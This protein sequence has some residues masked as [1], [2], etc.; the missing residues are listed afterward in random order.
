GE[1]LL[2]DLQSTNGTFV[3]AQRAQRCELT[4]GD[5]IQLG[6]N[7][8]LRFAIVDDAE[9]EM[10]RRLYESSTRDSLTRAY[11]RKYFGERLLAEIAHAQR[12]KNELS[13]LMLDLDEF[14][15]VNDKYGHLAG[16]MVLRTV[17]AQ[18]MRLIRME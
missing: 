3:G 5:R 16:D 7:L 10:Q 8:L 14:K 1:Y 18:M 17:A 15:Q 4:T 11:N 9:E 13:L 12:H 6:P 2:E